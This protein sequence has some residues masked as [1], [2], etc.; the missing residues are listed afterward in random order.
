[1][2][3]RSASTQP[4]LFSRPTKALPMETEPPKPD[5]KKIDPKIEQ[6]YQDLRKEFAKK[7]HD[8]EIELNK[9]F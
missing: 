9:L 8:Y 5:V 6:D 2:H 4:R 1:V 7:R 3:T